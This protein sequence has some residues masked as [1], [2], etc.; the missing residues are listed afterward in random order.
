MSFD[1]IYLASRSP[2]RRELLRQIGVRFTA[3]SADVDETVQPGEAPVAYVSRLAL[4]KARTLWQQVA[5]GQAAA[6]P[7]LG[8]DTTVVLDNRILGKPRDQTEA[9]SML[10]AL[11]GRR[12]QVMTAVALVHDSGVEQALVT[13]EVTFGPISAEQAAAYWAT[14][15]PADKAGGYGIQGLGAVF[16][17]QIKG[18][19]TAV[20]GLPLFETANLLRKVG[21]R[22]WQQPEMT[23]NE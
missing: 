21:V 15:E 18:S 9:A 13:T 7:V 19:Y 8:S 17:E 11:A 22:L 16:V 4:L 6:H 3:V 23:G 14:G 1:G 5:V 20:V 12:H 2:R 10:L